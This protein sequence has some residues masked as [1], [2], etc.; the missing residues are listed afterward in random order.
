MLKNKRKRIVDQLSQCLKAYESSVR[1]YA[2]IQIKFKEQMKSELRQ[3]LQIPTKTE[4]M[5]TPVHT[6]LAW[7]DSISNHTNLRRRKFFS[8]SKFRFLMLTNITAIVFIITYIALANPQGIIAGIPNFAV[9]KYVHWDD[10]VEAKIN[11][12]ALNHNIQESQIPRIIFGFIPNGF[13][14]VEDYSCEGCNQEV[15]LFS[16]QEHTY[17]RVFI[18]PV[19]EDYSIA[20]GTAND[21]LISSYID[22]MEVIKTSNGRQNDQTLLY[23]WLKD[24]HIIS[25]IAHDVSSESVEEMIS[26]ISLEE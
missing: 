8:G 20:M 1:E 25:L 7:K 24:N 22:D 5:I 3:C 19:K 14:Q 26:G 12:D 21:E 9:E 23:V 16:K 11:V 4:P 15:Y 2:K 18:E 17:I 6:P 13:Q 10:V